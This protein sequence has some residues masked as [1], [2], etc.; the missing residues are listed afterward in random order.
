M[1]KIL[2]AWVL[3]LFSCSLWA[4]TFQLNIEPSQSSFPLG[5]PVQLNVS[6]TNTSTEAKT[7]PQQFDPQYAFIRYEIG[8]LEFNAWEQAQ[9]LFS[10]KTFKP[11]ETVTQQVP[12]FFGAQGW[13]FHIAGRYSV[14]AY[15]NSITSNQTFITITP[16][17]TENEAK[18]ADLFL[19][20]R[21]VGLLML[22]KHQNGLGS[23]V[24]RLKQVMGLYPETIHARFATQAFDAYVENRKRYLAQSMLVLSS[25]TAT[26]WFNSPLPKVVDD[27]S[28]FDEI[29]Q[30]T[31]GSEWLNELLGL[32]N[33]LYR[34]SGYVRD[35]NGQAINGVDIQ[36]DSLRTTTDADGFYQI[37]NLPEAEYELVATKTGYHFNPTEFVVSNNN[38]DATVHVSAPRSQ[39]SIEIE[40]T[41]AVVFQSEP[42]VTYS[43]QVTN[44][45]Q[46]TATDVRI[47]NV[48]PS[49]VTLQTI[50]VEQGSCQNAGLNINCSLSSLSAGQTWVVQIHTVPDPNST[51]TLVNTAQVS[52]VQ[53][54]KDSDTLSTQIRPHFSAFLW[55]NPNPVLIN[56]PV[57]YQA[58][59]I[60]SQYS[61]E[62]AEQIELTLNLP[63][64]TD[65]LMAETQ[66][67]YCQSSDSK[68]NCYLDAV[69]PDN[70]T[71]IEIMATPSQSG[72]LQQSFSV[73]SHNF[74][75]YRATQNLTVL[76]PAAAGNA[77]VALLIDDTGSMEQDILAVRK[78]LN[79]I[80]KEFK[81]SSVVMPRIAILTFKDDVTQR[82]VS[83][84]FNQL[85]STISRLNASGGGLCPEAS[86]QAMA[87][88]L[89][90]LKDGGQ[91][92]LVT[93]ASPHPDTHA[94]EIQAVMQTK[95]ATLNVMLSGRCPTDN[96]SDPLVRDTKTRSRVQNCD[97]TNGQQ[98]ADAAAVYQ[99]MVDSTQG[100]YAWHSAVKAGRSAQL[101]TDI[102]TVLRLAIQKLNEGLVFTDETEQVID[103]V[104]SQIKNNPP[105]GYTVL[106]VASPNG[107][108]IDENLNIDC[109]HQT[110]QYYLK[111]GT[112]VDLVPVAPEGMYLHGW[113]GSTGCD[114]SIVMRG[115]KGCLALFYNKP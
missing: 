96:V 12:I 49:N 97:I 112:R 72:S 31:Q 107:R 92:L 66:G 115:F 48:L 62:T 28:R 50:D 30:L 88:G 67:G 39:V 58:R 108:V 61:P 34:V 83:S 26:P 79:S 74:S 37:S 2:V 52:S 60:N 51:D 8:G 10:Q 78:A 81:D 91:L 35:K 77:D 29:N 1:N 23:G 33:D 16:V 102:I 9:H 95:S 84:D 57:I 44:E 59:V 63:D 70:H 111:A 94:S 68:V 103:A 17:Q 14:V 85:L 114:M 82:I 32:N 42:L 43:L 90:L 40:T 36:I 46:D 54:P 15:H 100:L 98:V 109:D 18:A 99:C 71:D 4:N 106:S 87:E 53:Y 89:N 104:A 105:L 41:P 20:S 21:Q 3:Y 25:K 13:V 24:E 101:E 76:D 55:T 5:T 64:D 11:N 113:Y 45:G 38:P 86:V 93:D 22:D 73:T 47:S 56:E 27:A 65:F 7:L 80:I 69:E 19:Q 110:C 6:L 75:D